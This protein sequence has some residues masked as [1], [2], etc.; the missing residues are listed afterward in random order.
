MAQPEL[1]LPQKRSQ[2]R[3]QKNNRYDH[4]KEDTSD[5][6]SSSRR[7]SYSLLIKLADLLVNP[8]THLGQQRGVPLQHTPGDQRL[9]Q[10]RHIWRSEKIKSHQE[11]RIGGRGEEK[12]SG[13]T[14]PSD[15][16]VSRTSARRATLERSSTEGWDR[17][18][19][20]WAST[21]CRSCF[22]SSPAPPSI[23]LAAGGL[24]SVRFR[25]LW[26]RSHGVSS[27]AQAAVCLLDSFR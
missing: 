17:R 27:G 16:T 5:C 6:L 12:R 23:S 4:G 15:F 25:W 1:S 18:K 24:A 13:G 19:S 9:K 22:P 10:R 2:I 20:L 14:V 11:P 8:P 21:R 26:L 7:R 3:Y